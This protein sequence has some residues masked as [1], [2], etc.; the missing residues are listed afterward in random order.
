MQS[1]LRIPATPARLSAQPTDEPL[2]TP[3]RTS[4]DRKVVQLERQQQSP[5]KPTFA[6]PQ[7]AWAA[8]ASTRRNQLMGGS[9]PPP[10]WQSPQEQRIKRMLASTGGAA[11]NAF[12]AAETSKFNASQPHARRGQESSIAFGTPSPEEQRA[13]LSYLASM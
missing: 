2:R 13:Y 6:E 9:V 11:T 10:Q 1:Q 3:H 8:V 7:P 12:Y 4:L 5:P